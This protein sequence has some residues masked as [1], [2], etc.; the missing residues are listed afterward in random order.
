MDRKYLFLLVQDKEAVEMIL[1]KSSMADS[2]PHPDP[3]SYFLGLPG[4]TSVNQRNGSDDLDPH[5]DTHKNVTDPH[6]ATL[7][8]SKYSVNKK[9]KKFRRD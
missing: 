7:L 3:D 6:S 9:G 4:S 2:D 8:Y 1:E 5:P